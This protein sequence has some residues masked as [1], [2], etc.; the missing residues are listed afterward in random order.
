MRADNQ[1]E[2][3][4]LALLA[5]LISS[6]SNTH[7]A[8]VIALALFGAALIYGDGMITPA[9]SVL[10]AVE[11]FS[12]ATPAFEPYV[13]PAAVVILIALFAVQQLGTGSIGAVFGPVMLVWFAVIAVMGIAQLV[14]EPVVL[15]ALSPSYAVSF[16]IDNRM[17]GFL[18]LGSVFLVVTGS[19]A[20][21][22]DMGHFGR[23]PITIGWLSVVFPSLMLNYAG[24]GA[25]LLGDASKI[26]NP[27][28]LM[29][30]DMMRLP[31]AVLATAATVIASQ[32]LISGASSLTAQ[33]VQLDYVPRLRVLHTSVLERGQIY[34]PFV[35]W[36]LMVACIGLVLGFGSSSRLAAA[37]GVGVTA[38]MVIDSLLLFLIARE[39]WRW[40]FWRAAALIAVFL[41]VDLAFFGANLFKIP[42][43]GWVPLLIAALV[44]ALMSTWRRGRDLV[45]DRLRGVAVSMVAFRDSL[46][47]DPPTRIPGTVVF[48]HRTPLTVP[49]A[50]LAILRTSRSL[51]LE[52]VLLA[53]I[54]DEELAHV[55]TA[56]RAT[57]TELG[58][59]F[60]QIELRFG[61]AERPNI[62][63][64]LSEMFSPKFGFVPEATV[65]VLGTE[66]VVP[67]SKPGMAPWREEVFAF[68]Y[69]NASPA[70]MYFGLPSD[71]VIEIGQQVEL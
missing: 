26:D 48:L 42:D 3:G 5:L 30:P 17:R 52:S 55:P 32:A 18:A 15:R 35:N 61:F 9:I 65:Y 21:F 16:F 43:G 41:V 57:V 25:T 2:G 23:R 13:I 53:V 28:Y 14:T 38:T 69:R 27:F 70:A 54:T 24:Q 58:D 20:L 66:R 56:G 37:Y 67:T 50:M 51:P 59:G 11:G 6:R 10:S 22:A 71:R 36:T 33:A 34:V 46:A 29:V 64:A 1:G 19:E 8:I 60:F 31:M 40:P 68:L 12:V 4:I 44:F 45:H 49:P 39:R 62:P 63:K 47:H 7:R